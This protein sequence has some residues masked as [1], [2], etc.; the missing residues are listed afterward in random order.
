MSDHIQRVAKVLNTEMEDD[1]T[2]KMSSPVGKAI[3]KSM[4]TSQK[5]GRGIRRNLSF[6]SVRRIGQTT[7][8]LEKAAFR[9]LRNRDQSIPHLL[10]D[11]MMELGCTYIKLGQLIASSPSLFPHEYV[12]AFQSCLDKTPPV[13]FKVIDKILKQE[14][15]KDYTA[16]Y[17]E[18]DPEP[19]ATAS[20]AQVHAAT[21]HNGDKVVIKIQKPDVQQTLE[22]DFQFMHISARLA[23]FLPQI[24][25]SSLTDIVD[26]IRKGMLEECDFYKEARNIHSYENFLRD[27]NIH[28]VVV[29][30]VYLA[31]TRKKILTMERFFGAPLSDLKKVRQYNKNPEQALIDALNTWFMSLTQC[32]I[33]H[34]DLHAG[35]VMMLEDG[36]VGFID[37][38]IVGR[39]SKPT[40]DAL[41]NLTIAIPAKDYLGIAK[42]LIGI[43]ATNK[44]VNPVSFARDIENL[45]DRIKN[46]PDPARKTI[47]SYTSE[48]LPDQFMQEFTMQL[49]S[50]GKQHG[51]RFPREFTLL[52]K[53]FLYFDRYIRLL[54]PDL[55][56]FDDERVILKDLE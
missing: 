56:I 24:P 29:P 14:L 21:W 23:E 20:I 47:N 51:I 39:I 36:R 44:T 27:H 43:G 34:A 6:H 37:F 55:Q 3:G 33:Y 2:R 1:F 30:K 9:W 11:T 45:V 18:I 32:Q 16:L 52:I 15:G 31:G 38:G 46:P 42:S 8:A 49:S 10:R 17:Q 40:W 12:D 28:N 48:I 54:A 13:P 22:T 25:R 7:F 41:I 4:S 35:N 19:L 5:L 50:I 26:E 53:Q